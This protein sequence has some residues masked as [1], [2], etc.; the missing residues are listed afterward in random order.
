MTYTFKPTYD[1]YAELGTPLCYY[2][3]QFN[4]AQ[5][6]GPKVWKNLSWPDQMRVITPNG[7]EI[8]DFGVESQLPTDSA[9]IAEMYQLF[10][11]S[12]LW[13]EPNGAR[14]GVFAVTTVKGI[15]VCGHHVGIPSYTDSKGRRYSL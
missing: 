9:F 1:E 5:Y 11:R 7:Y 10:G 15:S 3:L 14:L 8:Q 13:I 4:N 2:C 12:I 6:G